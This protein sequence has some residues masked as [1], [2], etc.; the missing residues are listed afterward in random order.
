MTQF[1]IDQIKMLAKAFAPDQT[2]KEIMRIRGVSYSQAKRDYNKVFGQASG[3]APK[4]TVAAAFNGGDSTKVVESKD[5]EVKTVE[6]LI[7]RAKIDMTEWT[8]RKVTSNMYAGNFQI[9]AEF[10]RK[11]D[12]KGIALLT[13][14]F[15][16]KAKEHAPKQFIYKGPVTQN[17]KLLVLNLQ[18]A[19]FGKLCWAKETGDR[20]YD[21]KISKENY[22]NA[23]YELI[24][25]V[26]K[27]DVT[28]VLF[29]L[30]SDLLHFDTEQTTTTGGT[31]LDSDTR[32]PKM[33]DETCA[34]ITKIIENISQSFEVEVMVVPGNHGRLSEYCLG[35]YVKAWFRLN[36]NVHVNN[37]PL[38]RKYFGFGT[39]LIGF[40]HG[41]DAK[42]ADLPL[43][44]MRENQSTVS[45][46]TQMFFLTGHIHTDKMLEFKGVKVFV[47]PALCPPDKWHSKNGYVGNIQTS[48]AIL[49]DSQS[50][51]DAIYYSTPVN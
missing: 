15:E 33:Y 9:K 20:D 34:L 44:M 36:K 41:D 39:N 12:E 19:H 22:E 25:K 23:V 17:G 24:G 7:A 29:I 49:F 45:S 35:S 13:K 6:D 47:A 3:K 51:L 48:Q 43:T 32:W 16:D 38:D 14:L 26:P 4:K 46:Y 31:R 21:L 50:G 30:G 40:A 27:D 11:R 1:E 2:R 10:E 42:M 18:D 8:V 28:K 37:D 5:P